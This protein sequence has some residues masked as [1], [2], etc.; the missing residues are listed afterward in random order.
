MARKDYIE[1][2]TENGYRS[3]PIRSSQNKIRVRKRRL[4]KRWGF[5]GVGFILLV[6]T[7]PFTYTYSSYISDS[8]GDPNIKIA[9]WKY[10]INAS[11]DQELVINLADTI[12]DNNYSMTTVIPGTRG[13]IPL[14]IDFSDSKVASDYVITLDRSNYVLPDNLKLY[15]D[16]NRTIEFQEISGS[17]L[18]DDPVVTRYIYWEWKYTEV[19]ETAEWT[20]RELQVGFTIDLKQK[21]E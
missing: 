13:A 17:V 16:E 20:D 10:R 7:V 5:L 6:L 1:L 21:I 15:A 14:E 18:L 11:N 3:L 12:T 8:S 19:G 2:L 4:K 9:P